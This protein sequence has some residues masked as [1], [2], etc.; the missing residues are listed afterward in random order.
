MLATTS[1]GAI[2]SSCSPDFGINGVVDRFGQI[3]PKVLFCADGY[4]YNGKR[5]D[6][7]VAVAGVVKAIDSIAH[8]VVVPFTGDAV[9]L[10]ELDGATLWQDFTVA[11][12]PLEFT[13]LPFNH[14]L[15]VMYSSGTT[16]VPK[17]IVHGC[18]GTL[19]QHQKEHVL[20]ISGPT[21]GCSISRPVAG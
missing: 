21:I 18:G 8:T 7:L 4:F 13:P 10:P 3:E 20:Q 17:C 11:G 14:P 15:Y 19:L 6:S 1:I 2:W 16:G 9:T 12:R 5:I